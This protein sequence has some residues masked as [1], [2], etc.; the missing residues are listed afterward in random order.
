M[1]RARAASLRRRFHERTTLHHHR[2]LTD[3]LVIAVLLL[4]LG[5][6][7]FTVGRWMILGALLMFLPKAFT[8]AGRLLDV[9]LIRDRLG[10]EP[11]KPG[12][13]SIRRHSGT[14][15][16]PGARNRA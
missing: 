2:F 13:H 8:D 5:C 11:P 1:M 9:E 6:F 4:C 3:L 7:W 15:P 16:R 14:H 12:R 10:M